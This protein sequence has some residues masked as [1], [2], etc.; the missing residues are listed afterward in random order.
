VG[1]EAAFYLLAAGAVLT[2]LGV[3]LSRNVVHAA[4][5]M[6]ANFGLTA[7]LYLLLQ[8]PFLAAAQL[9]VYA[10]AI[11]VLFLFVIMLLGTRE[12]GL[13]ESLVGHRPLAIVAV[14]LL[15]GLLT[16]GVIGRLPAVT[17]EGASARTAVPALAPGQPDLAFGSPAAV[18]EALMRRHMLGLEIVSILLL[19]AMLG[20]VVLARP[21]GD[22]GAVPA[23]ATDNAA[24]AA[25]G[26]ASPTRAPAGG[27]MDEDGGSVGG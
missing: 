5:L 21:G 8:A 23:A 14:V 12:V 1:A 13:D 15:I 17:P 6:V 25:G 2:A 10:G 24:V 9:I 3:M 18:G 26:A 19:V 11:M 7:A 16:V 20:V 27:P 22:G 4:L